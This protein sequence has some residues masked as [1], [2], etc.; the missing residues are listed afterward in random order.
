MCLVASI[1]SP[2]RFEAAD[3]VYF[4]DVFSNQRGTQSYFLFKRCEFSAIMM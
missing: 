3:T 4:A 1:G 2:E